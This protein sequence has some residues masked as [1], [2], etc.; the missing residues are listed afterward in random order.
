[1]DVF[2]TWINLTIQMVHGLEGDKKISMMT[3]RC[4]FLTLAV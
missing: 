1:M 4:S 2:F 3:R